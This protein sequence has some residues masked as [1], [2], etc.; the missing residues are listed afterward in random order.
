MPKRKRMV[1]TSP[2]AKT[3]ATVR[4]A[5]PK[6][7]RPREWVKGKAKAVEKKYRAKRGL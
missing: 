7:S 5:F 2:W 3:L 6:G 4:H 1:L